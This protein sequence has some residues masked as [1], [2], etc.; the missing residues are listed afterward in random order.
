MT[1]RPFAGRWRKFAHY[2]NREAISWA[3]DG[4]VAVHENASSTSKFGSV[5][6]FA[7]DTEGLVDVSHYLRT[8]PQWFHLT[9]GREHLDLWGSHM[10]KA[11]K[12]CEEDEKESR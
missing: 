6:L 2:Q 12:Y 8:K 10:D 4:G 11:L 9:Q 5:H 1:E 7:P 3:A